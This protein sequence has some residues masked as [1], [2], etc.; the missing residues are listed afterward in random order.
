D[1][2]SVV[3]HAFFD[4]D[5][6]VASCRRRRFGDVEIEVMR[7]SLPCELEHVTKTRRREHSRSRPFALEHGIGRERRSQNEKLDVATRKRIRV[8]ELSD[9]IEYSLRRIG[10][11]RRHFVIMVTTALELDRHEVGECAAGIDTDTDCAH[12]NNSE[13]LEVEDAI[14]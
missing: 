10:G 5:T 14:L 8:E 12:R 9:A 4:F 2:A 3:R 11:R 6:A 13:V 1:L 7:P